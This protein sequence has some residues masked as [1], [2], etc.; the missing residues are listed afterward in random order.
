[1]RVPLPKVNSTLKFFLPG[2]DHAL[3]PDD[4]EAL[5]SLLP[6][7]HTIQSQFAYYPFVSELFKTYLLTR[8]EVQFAQLAISPAPPGTDTSSLWAT[9]TK[10]FAD[11]ALY[12]E[13][14]AALMA[15]PY[16]KQ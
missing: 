2:P 5:T 11:L 10:G 14:Y 13:A 9:V 8:Y 12:E 4:I 6:A 16:E 15:M 3:S 1:M 7:A